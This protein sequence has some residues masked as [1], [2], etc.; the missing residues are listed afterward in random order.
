MPRLRFPFA[1]VLLAVPLL[2]ACGGGGGAVEAPIAP[3]LG[4]LAIEVAWPATG[5]LVP[6]NA[7]SI[8]VEVSRAGAAFDAA[9]LDRP[10]TTATFA[11]LPVGP[12]VVTA[13]AFADPGGAGALLASATLNASIVADSTASISLTMASELTS[14]VAAPS[15]VSIVTGGS[16]VLG[17]SALNRLGQ[18]VLLDPSTVSF[19][20]DAPA[21]VTVASNGAVAGVGVGSAT[22]TISEGDSGLTKTVP[23]AVVA[24]AAVSPAT[25]S[26]T[27]GDRATFGAVGFGGSVAWSVQEAGG[28]TIAGDGTYTAPKRKGTYHVVATGAGG[29]PV[30]TATVTVTSGSGTVVVN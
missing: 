4:R 25:A 6:A 18:T 3:A 11:D 8:V 9:T 21:V 10:A 30:A 23:A 7:R 14:L 17:V 27:V 22:I 29:A 28:G 13:K 26:L 12:V 20:S 15:A 19:A 5:R 1:S 16:V 2:S 24:A